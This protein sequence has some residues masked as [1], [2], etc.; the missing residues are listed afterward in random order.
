M[1]RD[2][3]L[4]LVD[5]GYSEYEGSE[6]RLDFYYDGG[7]NTICDRGWDSHNAIVACKQLGYTHGQ[8]VVHAHYGQGTGG[9]VMSW[10]RCNGTEAQLIDCPF[11]HG[12]FHSSCR[13]SEDAGVV[14][15]SKLFLQL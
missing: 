10:V 5:G 15:S 2:G 6:G 14:C 8:A 11:F 9:I 7:W 3:E 4:R 13:H 1:D 12:W